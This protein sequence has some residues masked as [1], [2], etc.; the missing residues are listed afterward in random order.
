VGLGG[1]EERTG[2][3]DWWCRIGIGLDT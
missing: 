3:I 2:D 1:G